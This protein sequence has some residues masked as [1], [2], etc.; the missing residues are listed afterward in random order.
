MNSIEDKNEEK[1]DVYGFV[2]WCRRYLIPA[3]KVV[4][5]R[6]DKCNDEFMDWKYRLGAQYD[7]IVSYR[8]YYYRWKI[9]KKCNWKIMRKI[10]R[11]QISNTLRQWMQFMASYRFRHN[12]CVFPKDKI[13]FWRPLS[14]LNKFLKRFWS[15]TSSYYLSF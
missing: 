2:V 5:L 12:V 3:R 11:S 15:C 7:S 14:E 10:H 4:K 13:E 8:K 6:S 9:S 1:T